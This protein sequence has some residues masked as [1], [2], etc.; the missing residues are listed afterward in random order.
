MNRARARAYLIIEVLT[1]LGTTLPTVL[2]NLAKTG[3][4]ALPP[5]AV[6]ILLTVNTIAPPLI[7]AYREYTDTTT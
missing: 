2:V 1:V 7:A 6:V 5:L 4:V 3:G